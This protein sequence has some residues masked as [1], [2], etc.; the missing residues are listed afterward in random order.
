MGLNSGDVVVGKIGDDLRMDYTAQGQTVGVAQRMEQRAASDTTY[1]SESTAHLVEGFFELRDLGEFDLKGMSAPVRAHELEGVGSMRT[2]LQV[3]RSRGFSR[4]VGRADEMG[5]LEGALHRA[6]EGNGQVVGVVG[7]AGVGK[8]RLCLE[9]VEQSRAKGIT[10]Y[11]A[12]CPSHGKTIPFLPV[13][14]LFRAVFGVTEQDGPTEARRK[15]AGTLVLLDEEFREILPVVFEFLGVPDP[16]LPAPRMGPEARKRQLLAFVQRL[17]QARSQREPAITLV[18][19][20]HWIDAGSDEFLAQ[21]VEAT[22]GTRTLLLVNFRPE[23]H[24]EW[25]GRSYCQQLPLVPLGSQAAEELLNDLLGKDPSVTPLLKLVRDRTGGNPFFIE[26]IVQSLVEA[27][28]LQGGRGAYRLAGPVEKLEVPSTVQSV[29]TARIDRLVE[30]DKQVLQTAAVIG[31]VF[32]EPILEEVIELPK[33]DLLDALAVLKASEFIY[34]QAIYPV[35]EYAFKHPLTQ[36][37]AYTSQLKQRRSRVH[38]AVAD[39]IGALHGEQIEEHAALLAHHCEAAGEPLAAARW[40]GRAAGHAGLT[41]PGEELRL[42]LKVRSLVGE[43]PRDAATAA[44][45]AR[46]CTRA[47]A[48]ALAVWISDEEAADLFEEGKELA[49]LAGDRAQ[50]A[51]LIYRYG[52]Y[53]GLMQGAIQEWIDLSTEALCLAQEAADPTVEFY[54]QMGLALGLNQS[55]R[56]REA[57]ALSEQALRRTDDPHFAAHLTGRS[58]YLYLVT[59]HARALVLMGRLADSKAEFDRAVLLAREHGYVNSLTEALHGR[60]ER[61]MLL[62]ESGRAP[63]DAEELMRIA[64]QTGSPTAK[65]AAL[66]GFAKAHLLAKD[67]ADAARLID[68]SGDSFD[69]L[70]ETSRIWVAQV[71]VARARL[72]SAADRHDEARDICESALDRAR[73]MGFRTCECLAQITLAEVLRCTEAIGAATAIRSALVRARDL[74]GQTE[75]CIY[76]PMIVEEE[77][78]L[79]ELEGDRSAC[80]T[81]L[82]EAHRLFVEMGATGH[83]RRLAKELGL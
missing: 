49:T 12:H 74:V 36:E 13:L 65:A 48:A 75:A 35:A 1:L 17:V 22:S 37:V 77:A 15:I 30:R 54:I 46:A 76:E 21:L 19:D 83:A 63:A 59:Q 73:Q 53:R 2:R 71:L 52:I 20:L 6:T 80:D 32:S 67:A 28:S 69:W 9:F 72:L 16:E 58:P 50:H 7:E 55:G 78:R 31:K 57:L 66:S 62:G 25:M 42:W 47:L 56:P 4:F 14:E 39:A 82:R 24:A 40:A 33:P 10:V 81:N 3:A 11:E 44:L 8:S 18:D 26:E 38:G 27:G 79:A 34:E 45:G 23:Y 51:F 5:T 64:Q 61:M 70:A 68:A 43:A 41:H 29:L 60:I